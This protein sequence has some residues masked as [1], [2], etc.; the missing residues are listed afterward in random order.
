MNPFHH[1]IRK[2]DE[3]CGFLN[4]NKIMGFTP[5]ERSHIKTATE[6]ISIVILEFELIMKNIGPEWF[7]SRDRGTP[8]DVLES[9]IFSL[10]VLENSLRLTLRTN[11]QTYLGDAKDFVELLE[12]NVSV[13]CEL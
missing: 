12:K 6:K 9:I 5:C 1:F 13:I 4:R 7:P 11:S 10:I 8:R 3:L 2:L